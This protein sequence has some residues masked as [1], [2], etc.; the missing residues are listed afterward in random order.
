MHFL[1]LHV[2][3]YTLHWSYRCKACVHVYI[4]GQDAV[5]RGCVVLTVEQEMN[6]EALRSG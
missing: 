4:Y 6:Y 2:E 3:E 5:N 1:S